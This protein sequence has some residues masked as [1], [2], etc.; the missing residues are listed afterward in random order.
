M[1]NVILI[2]KNTKKYSKI[3]FFRER[4]SLENPETKKIEFPLFCRFKYNIPLFIIMN[5][6][7]LIEKYSTL[8]WL[9]RK[10]PEDYNNPTVKAIIDE[11]C[12]KYPEETDELLLGENTEWHHGF[13]SG[14]LACLRLVSCARIYPN[15][16][17]EFP[18]LD[19]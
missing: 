18:F 3:F 6:E 14:M 11:T 4:E 1:Y 17:E 8:V 5:K 12:E 13:N 10:K 19:T 7:E 15:N 9:A 2:R 16:M